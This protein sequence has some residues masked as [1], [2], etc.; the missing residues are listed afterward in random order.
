VR[1][2]LPPLVYPQARAITATGAWGWLRDKSA[3]GTER[4]LEFDREFM[5]L[6]QSRPEYRR[7]VQSELPSDPEVYER[8]FGARAY[9]ELRRLKAELDPRQLLNRGSVFPAP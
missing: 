7:Y 5:A 8:C 3:A 6:A 4:L 9:G 2:R 1:G